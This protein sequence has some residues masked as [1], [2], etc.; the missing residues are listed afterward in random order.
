MLLVMV[1]P[2]LVAWN[3]KVEQKMRHKTGATKKLGQILL[4]LVGKKS[5]PTTKFQRVHRQGTRKRTWS[6]HGWGRIPA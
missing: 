2:M 3:E 1:I 6:E 5:L 4:V